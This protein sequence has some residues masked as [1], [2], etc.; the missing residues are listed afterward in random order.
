MVHYAPIE[1]HGII[2]DLHSVALVAQDGTIDWYCCPRFDSPSVFGAILDAEKGGAFKISPVDEDVRTKQLYLPDTNVLITRFLS[3]QGVGEVI[4]FMP[5]GSADEDR[6]RIV[7]MVQCVRGH[8]HFQLD[9]TPRFDYGRAEHTLHIDAHG[10]VFETD[11]LRM[12]LDSP[13]DLSEDEGGVHAFFTLEP[14][15]TRTFVLER[16]PDDGHSARPFPDEVCQHLFADTVDFWRRWLNQCSYRGRWRET[17]RRSALV[18]KLLCYRPTGAIV[19]APTTSLPEGI[20]GERNWDYR[21]TW[22][23]DASFTLY[24]F[25]KLGFTEEARDFMGFLKARALEQHSSNAGPLQIMYGIDGRHSLDEY[26]LDNLEGY[27]KSSPVRVGNGAA[28]QLQLDIYGEL[29]NSIYLYD[30]RGE[31]ID[32]ELWKVVVELLDWLMEHWDSKDEGIWE[33]RGGQQHF[34]YSRLMSWIAFDRALRIAQTRGFPCPRIAWRETRDAIFEQIMQRGYSKDR[35]AFVQVLDGDVLDASTLMMV[36]GHFVAPNDPL[37]VSTINAIRE[38]L[39]TDSLVY[40]YNPALAASDGL[41]GE[42]GTFSICSFWWV[43]ALARSGNLEEARLAFEKMHTYANHLGLYSE[44]IGPSGE[45]L[46]NFPQAFTHLSLIS[47]ALYLDRALEGDRA[48]V[49]VR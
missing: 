1:D 37:M 41:S 19:A 22:I 46:G 27:R 21:Y 2:G 18:L 3:D 12:A 4:D 34:T 23:R 17:V 36:M 28:G 42:E 33:V 49:G 29:I 26:E 47:A 16:I 15:D 6:H 35:Q 39:V 24:A 38:E 10:A 11:A 13:V 44:E 45:A 14:G 30:K 40:R 48:R 7:R 9:C 20:G 43:E 32:Y 31:P 5:I 25:L 8:M